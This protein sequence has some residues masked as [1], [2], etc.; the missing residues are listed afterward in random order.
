MSVPVRSYLGVVLLLFS[1]ALSTQQATA[2][3]GQFTFRHHYI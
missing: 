1:L 3:T 2:Q